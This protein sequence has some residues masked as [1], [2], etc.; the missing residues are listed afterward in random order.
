MELNLFAEHLLTYLFLFKS[1]LNTN[2]ESNGSR[3]TKEKPLVFEFA[4]SRL[5]TLLSQSQSQQALEYHINIK[6]MDSK[7]CVAKISN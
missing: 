2:H 5:T 4:L 3:K 1:H 6:S 7:W